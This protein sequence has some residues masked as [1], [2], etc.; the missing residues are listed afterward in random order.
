MQRE[1]AI[2]LF[3]HFAGS[4]AAV[5][6]ETDDGLGLGS[7]F[8]VGDGLFVTARHVA[9]HK[10]VSV[11]TTQPSQDRLRSRLGVER[12]VTLSTPAKAS[13]VGRVSF[14]PNDDVDIAVIATDGLGDAPS[15]ELND[16]DEEVGK[17][18]LLEPVLVMGYPRIPLTLDPPA[19]VVTTAEVNAAV[20]L[21]PSRLPA[22][23][24]S[25]MAR[26]G[27]SGGLVLTASGTA[28]GVVTQSLVEDHDR[29]QLGYL[30]ALRSAQ[31]LECL[32]ANGLLSK[33]TL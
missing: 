22:L 2:A 25:P 33:G 12:V 15:V 27:F 13:Y 18:L 14:H 30:S 10:I 3:E 11:Q 28:L 19:L 5:E 16:P 7:A 1:D 17:S 24:L 32:V 21:L 23:V 26:G 9:E 31:I 4:V 20:A 29:T 8:H 6:V